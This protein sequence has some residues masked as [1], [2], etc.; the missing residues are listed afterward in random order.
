MDCEALSNKRMVSRDI[1][2]VNIAIIRDGVNF[3]DGL[4]HVENP[5]MN[6][7]EVFHSSHVVA[8]RQ[9]LVLID[10]TIKLGCDPCVQ[11]NG[12]PLLMTNAVCV[13]ILRV[14]GQRWVY[15]HTIENIDDI[16]SK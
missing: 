7:I 6:E 4:L 15:F 9:Y 11:F 13:R 1:Q 3:C 16:L 12:I 14:K 5:I 2:A 10:E 8:N